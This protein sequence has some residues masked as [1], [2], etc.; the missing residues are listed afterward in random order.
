[1]STTGPALPGPGTS[2]G[3]TPVEQLRAQFVAL[4][5]AW[6]EQRWAAGWHSGI[7]D[8]ARRVGGLWL[9]MAA[10]CGGWPKGYEGEDGWEPLTGEESEA[11]AKLAG[12]AA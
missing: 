11:A 12:R 6:S 1:M 8:E 5:S 10:A 4:L 3:E 7:E 2:A 9:V